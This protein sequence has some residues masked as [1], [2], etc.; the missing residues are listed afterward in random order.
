MSKART[1]MKRNKHGR[2]GVKQFYPKTTAPVTVDERLESHRVIL[3]SI[4]SERD[5]L[6]LALEQVAEATATARTG[7]GKAAREIAAAALSS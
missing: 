4:T 7:S 3:T 6:R 5:R 2:T 1:K